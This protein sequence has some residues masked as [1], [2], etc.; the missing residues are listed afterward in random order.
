[1]Q[2]LN[3]SS[4]KAKRSE[5]VMICLYIDAALVYCWSQD[6]KSWQ[7]MLLMKKVVELNTHLHW[8]KTKVLCRYMGQRWL[9]GITS[10]SLINS[11][12]NINKGTRAGC[13][14]F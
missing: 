2:A 12:T 9:E 11:L 3:I 8:P 13:Q 14:S 10:N 1:M 7:Q 4:F 6:T 5:V